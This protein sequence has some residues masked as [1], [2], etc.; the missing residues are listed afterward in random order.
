MSL[1]NFLCCNSS[2]HERINTKFR[3]KVKTASKTVCIAD[4]RNHINNAAYEHAEKLALFG[5]IL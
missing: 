2:T 3:T 1:G 4:E 5:L